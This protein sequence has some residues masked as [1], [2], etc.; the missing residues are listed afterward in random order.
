MRAAHN[1]EMMIA[2][3]TF[4]SAK[5]L[6]SEAGSVSGVES[7]STGKGGEKVAVQGVPAPQA[8]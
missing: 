7:E 6:D 8:I 1:F 3:N 4:C 2:D 5:R